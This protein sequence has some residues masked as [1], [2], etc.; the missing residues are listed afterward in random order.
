MDHWADSGWTPGATIRQV[1]GI[2]PAGQPRE[3]GITTLSCH[4]LTPQ[5]EQKTHYF[6]AICR[7]FQL[8]NAQLDEK[9]RMGAE[10]TFIDQDERLLSA[11][12]ETVG[13]QDFWE[14]RPRL[15]LT[16]DV[17]AGRIRRRMDELLKGEAEMNEHPFARGLADA[18]S[19][20]ARP[21]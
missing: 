4:L 12:Q 3:Q 5:T 19:A 6:W 17:T 10:R 20:T 14:M 16:S 11:V 18:A 8:D 7:S 1:I 2:A 9:M 15:V 13:D 21:S